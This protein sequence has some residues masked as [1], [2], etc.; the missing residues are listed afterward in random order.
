MQNLL[1]TFEY[2]NLKPYTV[3][4]FLKSLVSNYGRSLSRDSNF[5][6]FLAFIIAV[7]SHTTNC[8]VTY[9]MCAIIFCGS[10]V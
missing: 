2:E 4:L 3:L 10:P 1:Y 7:K 9:H 5:T 8:Y 6:E